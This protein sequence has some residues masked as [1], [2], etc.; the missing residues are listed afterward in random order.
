LGRDVKKDEN[1][2][3]PHGFRLSWRLPRSKL[4]PINTLYVGQ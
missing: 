3:N 2:W 1:L 4:N